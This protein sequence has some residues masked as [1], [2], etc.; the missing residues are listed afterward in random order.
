MPR[1][2]EQ[3]DTEGVQRPEGDLRG[4][5]LDGCTEETPLT[6][7]QCGAIRYGTRGTLGKVEYQVDKTPYA[8][9]LEEQVIYWKWRARRTAEKLHQAETTIEANRL[10]VAFL[11]RTIIRLEQ[12]V[13]DMEDERKKAEWNAHDAW[14]A[15]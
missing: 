6:A 5:W 15:S 4:T 2:Q 11:G 10:H 14:A 7:E 9:D 13:R 1:L 3:A 12:Q 8:A